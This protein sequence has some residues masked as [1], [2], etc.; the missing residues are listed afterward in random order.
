[1][2]EKDKKE[3][4]TVHTGGAAYVGGD[5]GTGGGDFIGRDQVVHASDRGV[6]VG[7][8]VRDSTIVTGDENVMR[9][10]QGATLEEFAELLAQL[11]QLVA[12]SGLDRDAVEVVEGDFRVVQEQAEK[13]QP[14]RAI[15][16]SKLKGVTELLTATVGAAEAVQKLL[17]LAQQALQWA[18]Q[19]FR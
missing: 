17:P 6:A 19:L 9:A 2:S 4:P 14:S 15:I 12:Q 10:Q 16:L 5:V 7:G 3:T 8:D 18:G 1:M 11:R 13:P